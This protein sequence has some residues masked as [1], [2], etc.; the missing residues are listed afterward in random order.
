MSTSFSQRNG[1]LHL[2]PALREKRGPVTSHA[3]PICVA[4]AATATLLSLSYSAARGNTVV[5]VNGSNING[6]NGGDASAT[7]DP[8]G[9]ARG[10]DGGRGEDADQP[11]DRSGDGGR[12][13]N[14]YTNGTGTLFPNLFLDVRAAGG[15]GGGGGG[16]GEF[17][18]PHYDAYHAG[19]GGNA[20]VFATGPDLRYVVATGGAGGAGA[21][22]AGNGGSADAQANAAAI[23]SNGAYLNAHVVGGRGGGV[24]GGNGGA[25]SGGGYASSD[26]GGP[27]NVYLDVGGGSGG[28]N[29]GCACPASGGNGSPVLLNNAI[30]G[31]SFGGTVLMSQIAR[32]GNGGGAGGYDSDTTVGASG[33]AGSAGSAYSHLINT[34]SHSETSGEVSAT[35]YGGSGGSSYFTAVPKPGEPGGASNALYAGGST[36]LKA[37]AFGQGGDGGANLAAAGGGDYVTGGHDPAGAGGALGGMGTASTLVEGRRDADGD[38]TA[39]GG[40]GGNGKRGGQGGSASATSDVTSTQLGSK[41]GNTPLYAVTSTATA[42]GGAGGN[43]DTTQP[44]SPLDYEGG[45]GG[46]AGA[47]ANATV[48]SGTATATATATGGAGGSGRFNGQGGV[49]TA[50]ARAKAGRVTVQDTDSAVNG[51]T[52]HAYAQA[53][54]NVGPGA[55]L[56]GTSMIVGG[57][58][59]GT[60]MIVGGG[61]GL[62]PDS[63]QHPTLVQHAGSRVEMRG[64]IQIDAGAVYMLDGGTVATGGGVY[65]AGDL[66]VGRGGAIFGDVVNDGLIA[67]RDVAATVAADADALVSRGDFGGADAVIFGDV[68]GDGRIELA[69]GELVIT[70]TL[71]LAAGDTLE[72]VGGTDD[73]ALYVGRLDLGDGLSQLKST[74]T[75]GV[76]VFYDPAL[77]PDLGGAAMV[78]GDGRVHL[79]AG[80]L[81]VPEP[82]TAALLVGA[83]VGLLRRRRR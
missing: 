30:G 11:D 21:E 36:K 63:A 38:A 58:L 25:A 50:S 55:G 60:S 14:A 10:G 34:L 23:S 28:S 54:T 20:S 80:T 45:T 18:N 83:G 67:L 6:G 24:A 71:S 29:F 70:G 7:A 47:T 51:G 79:S 17:A 65:N 43:G 26:Y 19:D 53:S 82:T 1:N 81:P 72:L 44:G 78:L 69:G 5:G 3:R 59:V 8:T 15:M 40:N 57:G 31:Y 39:K 66:L 61:A 4:L 49:A 37:H 27:V 76:S 35:A 13:G 33:A 68:A 22:Q 12:G 56:V 42:T 52:A 75:G 74:G 32:G 77:N 9:Y 48:T 16:A 64:S 62:A 41:I 2:R 46:N 73:A